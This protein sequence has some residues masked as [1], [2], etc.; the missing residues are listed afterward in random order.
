MELIEKTIKIYTLELT[1]NEVVDLRN[2][3][4]NNLQEDSIGV[5]QRSTVEGLKKILEEVK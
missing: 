1:K 5:W 2:I 3:L 4:H